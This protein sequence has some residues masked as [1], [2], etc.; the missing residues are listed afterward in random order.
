MDLAPQELIE[1]SWEHIVVDATHLLES[2]LV[3][4]SVNVLF[5]KHIIMNQ[6]PMQLQ[7]QSYAIEI[8]AREFKEK[9]IQNEQEVN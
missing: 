6:S 8:P 3:S 9:K 4:Q 2:Q 1:V 7:I 5:N